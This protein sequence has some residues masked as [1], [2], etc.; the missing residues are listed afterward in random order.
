MAYSNGISTSVSD[1]VTATLSFAVT[2]GWTSGSTWTN[3]AY[4]ISS[5]SKNSIHYMLA[6]NASELY[7][8]SS[9]AISGTGTVASQTGA[10]QTSCRIH[11]IAGP[12]VGYHLFT[13]GV[14]L[15]CAVEVTTNSFT[16]FSFGEVTKTGTFNGG[17]F[18]TGSCMQLSGTITPLS[19]QIDSSSS[20]TPFATL[21]VGGTINNV[22]FGHMRMDALSANSIYSLGGAF[23]GTSGTC[24]NIAWASQSMRFVINGGPNTF[25]GRAVIIPM[26]FIAA[27]SGILTPYYQIGCLMNCGLISTIN[28]NPKDIVNT[29]WMVFPIGTKGTTSSTSI[30]SQN[31]GIAYKK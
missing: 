12:H 21:S 24:W 16:H 9:K 20:D 17:Q 25:N 6:Y 3:G 31:Y 19:L 22:S 8:N 26:Q 4:T 30:N 1:L 14:A 15:H 13:D 29:D 7:L 18:V 11:P 5:V 27:S 28:I 23:T 2:N 10:A